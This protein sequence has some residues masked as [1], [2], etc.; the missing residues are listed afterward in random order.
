MVKTTER[1]LGAGHQKQRRLLLPLA[2]GRACPL[3]GNLMLEGQPLDLDH[4][5]PRVMGGA[6]GPVRMVHR[7]CNRRAGA[8]LGN[9]LQKRRRQAVRTLR[10]RW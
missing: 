3:C 4:V 5:L 6:G 9:R 8:R 7:R 2:Y 10:T 1:G